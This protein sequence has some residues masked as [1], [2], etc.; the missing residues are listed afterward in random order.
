M[1]FDVWVW[2]SKLAIALYATVIAAILFAIIYYC[3]CKKCPLKKKGSK[4][5]GP[6]KWV[7]ETEKGIDVID[8][9]IELGTNAV[10][11]MT[12]D[13]IPKHP[14]DITSGITSAVVPKVD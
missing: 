8:D 11:H 13:L 1:R 7:C 10:K 2:D 5:V 4:N 9:D 6:K 12:L 14:I 3:I